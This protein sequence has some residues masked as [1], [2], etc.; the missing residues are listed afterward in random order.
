MIRKPKIETRNSKIGASFEFRVSIF[1][2][3]INQ[4]AL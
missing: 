3:S 4:D 1:G 2:F